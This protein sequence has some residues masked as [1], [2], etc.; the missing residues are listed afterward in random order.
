LFE[1]H[2]NVAGAGVKRETR[3]HTQNKAKGLPA[4]GKAFESQLL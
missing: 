4:W 2:N 3:F 1:G